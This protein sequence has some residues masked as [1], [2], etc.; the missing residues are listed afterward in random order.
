MLNYNDLLLKTPAQINDIHLGRSSTLTAIMQMNKTTWLIGL[1]M[2]TAE[3]C[4]LLR[5][6]LVRGLQNY[7]SN[8][9]VLEYSLNSIFGRR[10]QFPVPI[11]QLNEQLLEIY[12]NLAP[13]PSSCKLRVLRLNSLEIPLQPMGLISIVPNRFSVQHYRFS[14]TFFLLLAW[15]I[16]ATAYARD[17]DAVFPGHYPRG[18][19]SYRCQPAVRRHGMRTIILSHVTWWMESR[20]N[21]IARA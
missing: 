7:S 21:A 12:A 5:R 18:L 4:L 11:F 6:T 13:P 8:V 2:L 14:H 9:S 15:D 20:L 10:Y 16:P 1:I 3:I 17:R 19:L